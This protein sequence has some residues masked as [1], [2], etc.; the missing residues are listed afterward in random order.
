MPFIG[1]PLAINITPESKEV[2]ITYTTQP[3]ADAFLWVEG[4]KPIPLHTKPSNF[5]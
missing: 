2:S 4:E 5:S 1:S 3:G